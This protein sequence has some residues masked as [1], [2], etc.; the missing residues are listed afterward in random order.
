[1]AVASLL[2]QENLPILMDPDEGCG[3]EQESS[4]SVDMTAQE[5]GL[6]MLSPEQEYD[7]SPPEATFESRFEQFYLQLSE[8]KTGG[9]VV[10]TSCSVSDLCPDVESGCR[11][12]SY[13]VLLYSSKRA[14]IA[15]PFALQCNASTENIPRCPV[16]TPHRRRW[17][18]K[19]VVN[20]AADK[21]VLRGQGIS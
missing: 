14:T 9:M 1:M 21:S 13:T 18:P 10:S 19:Y 15:W 17:P 3:R 7:S 6:V 2:E 4:P 12:S 16:I 20:T 5:A 8:G 11:F